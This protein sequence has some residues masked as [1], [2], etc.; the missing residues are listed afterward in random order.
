MRIRF[1]KMQGAGNDFVVLDET[2]RHAGPHGRAIPLSG[3]PPLRRGRRPDPYGAAPL[4]GRGQ[5]HRLSV[6]DPQRRRRR[7]GAVRQRRA[8]LHA[9][10][11]GAPADRQGHGARRNAG[12][13][14]RAAHERRRPRD[15]GH[16]PAHLRA[17]PRALRHRRA[18]PAAHGR[19][20]HL[21]PGTWHA[22]RFG[23]CFG[24][25]AV[26]GQPA[27]GAGGRQRRHG[28]GA[29]GRARKSSTTRAFRSG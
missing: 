5:R 1:T 28:A 2:A 8:L 20:A 12:R 29:S 17:G 11:A 4:Q 9:L 27:C 21:A 24:G 13:H 19:L 10:C 26:H 7:G 25:C 23:H 18:R 22:C 3:R 14:H 16:G 15:G 6:R